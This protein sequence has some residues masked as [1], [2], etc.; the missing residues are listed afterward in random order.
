[1]DDGE[2][3]NRIAAEDMAAD[4][5]PASEETSDNSETES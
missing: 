4:T 5:A 3:L 2:Y 1:M